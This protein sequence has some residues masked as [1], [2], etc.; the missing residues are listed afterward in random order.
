MDKFKNAFKWHKTNAQ[1]RGVKFLF[2]FEEWK[3][4]W[5]AT[6]HWDSRGVGKDKYCMCRNNDAGPYALWNVYCATN[7]KNLSDANLGKPKSEETRRRISVA[8][9]GQI[10]HWAIGHKNPMHNLETKAKF[11][12]A[13]SGGKHY[14]AKTVAT[15][16]GIWNSASEAAKCIGI[17]KPTVEWRC[18]NNYLGFSY[19]A[20]A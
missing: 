6:G 4:W 2:T 20:I 11:S 7:S 1:K 17:P 16:H 10:N 5:E 18:K 3:T 19:L 14:R 9:T 12:K 15:P 8:L 13:T